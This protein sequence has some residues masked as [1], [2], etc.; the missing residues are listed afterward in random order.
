[1]RLWI[2]DEIMW[3]ECMLYY[4]SILNMS[5]LDRLQGRNAYEVAF[6]HSVDISAYRERMVLTGIDLPRCDCGHV[7]LSITH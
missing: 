2:D 1:M 6:G 7:L 3:F 4:I 5:C